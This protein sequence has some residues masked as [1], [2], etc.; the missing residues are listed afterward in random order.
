MATLL[1]EF[2]KK[3]KKTSPSLYPALDP[4]SNLELNPQTNPELDPARNRALDPA[5]NPYFMK[6]EYRLLR[7][8]LD[9]YLVS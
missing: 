6:E 8:Y 1:D 4:D 5:I 7:K 3:I 9:K 2:L